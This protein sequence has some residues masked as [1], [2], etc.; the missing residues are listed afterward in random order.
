MSPFIEKYKKGLAIV[1]GHVCLL[2]G[3]YAPGLSSLLISV[4]EI[5]ST[6][7]LYG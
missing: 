4:S 6:P 2:I 3:L 1:L 5:N 7:S